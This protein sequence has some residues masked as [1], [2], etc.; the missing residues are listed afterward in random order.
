MDT[1]I[2]EAELGNFEREDNQVRLDTEAL[3]KYDGKG[4]CR[5]IEVWVE[6]EEKNQQWLRATKR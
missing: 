6:R 3:S 5:R 2:E 4:M 1:H